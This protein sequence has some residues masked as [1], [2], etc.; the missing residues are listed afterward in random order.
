[1]AA[2]NFV[3]TVAAHVPDYAF[4]MHA[5][6]GAVITTQ[7]CAAALIK[8]QPAQNDGVNAFVPSGG[9]RFADEYYLAR[10]Q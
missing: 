2:K 8:I 5:E 1:M 7:R 4:I 3:L 10:K 9:F 6:K